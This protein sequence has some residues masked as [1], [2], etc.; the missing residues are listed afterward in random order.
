MTRTLKIKLTVRRCP[1]PNYSCYGQRIDAK[2][3]Q[4]YPHRAESIIRIQPVQPASQPASQPGKSTVVRDASE[5]CK[6]KSLSLARRS[7]LPASLAPSC[8]SMHPPTHASLAALFFLPLG[9]HSRTDTTAY[10]PHSQN[11]PDKKWPV[12]QCCPMHA[13]PHVGTHTHRW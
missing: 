11:R 4:I 8:S 5:G 3:R 13:G 12:D 10:R 9:W 2:G 6:R 1:R 7:Q